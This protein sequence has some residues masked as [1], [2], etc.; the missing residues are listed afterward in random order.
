MITTLIFIVILGILI[1]VH[2]FGHLIA[3]KRAGVRVEKFSVGFG[4]QLFT[5]KKNNT[6]YSI[7]MIPLGGYVKLAGDNYE[8]YKGSADEYLSQSPGKRAKIIFFGPLLNYVL[9]FLFFW[10][11]FA[12]GYPTLTTRVGELIDGFGAKEAGIQTQDKIISVDG[13]RVQY[14]EELQAIIQTKKPDTQV[15][16]SVLRDN[17]EHDFKVVI[18]SREVND[19]FG[20]K[21][22][23]GMLGITAAGEVV[24]VRHGLLRSFILGINKTWDLTIITYK[25]LG[26]LITG[27]LSMRESVTGPLGIF[28]ITSKAAEIGMIAILQLMAVLSVSLAIFNLLPI[29]VLDGGHIF[30]LIVEKLR[31]RALSPKI[32]RIITQIGLSAIISLAIFTTYNDIVRFFGDKISKIFK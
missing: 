24:T 13:L 4:P 29:P 12:V 14:W 26:R 3:A 10:F 27:R 2:E 8:E 11:I 25:A 22:N 16:I 19:I 32:E 28:Y 21:R 31:G 5:C 30:L 17:K 20:D 18:K 6:E 9:G 15:D 7:S 1:I 23:I